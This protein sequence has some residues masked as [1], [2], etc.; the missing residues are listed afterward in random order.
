MALVQKGQGQTNRIEKLKKVNLDLLEST[1]M[2]REFSD[3]HLDRQLN[4]DGDTYQKT[5]HD[6]QD[7][8]TNMKS[9]I[10]TIKS[11]FEVETNSLKTKGEPEL[12]PHLIQLEKLTSDATQHCE[13]PSL[14]WTLDQIREELMKTGFIIQSVTIKAKK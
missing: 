9:K 7:L 10:Q 2:I 6:I 5:C 4:N 12:K 1:K 8:M 11:A 14:V 13:D 3:Q